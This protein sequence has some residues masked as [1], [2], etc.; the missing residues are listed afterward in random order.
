MTWPAAWVPSCPL[1]STTRVEATFSVSRIKVLARM[2]C[3]KYREVEGAATRHTDQYHDE[4]QHDVEREQD[5][6]ARTAAG[7]E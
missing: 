3:R 7:A 2:D 4:R 5:G 1:S 6:P